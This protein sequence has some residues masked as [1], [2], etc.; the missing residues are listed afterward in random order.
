[1]AREVKAIDV[2]D[3]PEALKIAEDV[4]ATDEPRILRRGSK[5]LA[6]VM[7]L[8]R[9]HRTKGKP[10]QPDDPLFDL[11]GIGDSGQGD[12]S[13]NKHRYLADAYETKGE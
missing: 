6:V 10:L 12:V 8:P 3:M 7:P 9:R 1:V 13:E 2:K 4:E 5:P 11:V